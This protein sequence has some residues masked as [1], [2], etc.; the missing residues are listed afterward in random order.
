MKKL[1]LITMLGLLFLSCEIGNPIDY[2]ARGKK[3]Y[4]T[5]EDLYEACIDSCIYCKST[6]LTVISKFDS[7]HFGWYSCPDCGHIWEPV[8]VKEIQTI[9]TWL[10]NN[11]GRPTISGG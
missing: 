10:L 5:T 7:P 6:N 1:F 3:Y 11:Y 2:N 4:Y 9:L 8:N